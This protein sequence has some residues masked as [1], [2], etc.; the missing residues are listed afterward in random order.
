TYGMC[1]VEFGSPGVG[2]DGQP[3]LQPGWTTQISNSPP[4]AIACATPMSP[5]LGVHAHKTAAKPVG[6]GALELRHIHPPR[7]S[8]PPGRHRERGDRVEDRRGAALLPDVARAL[9]A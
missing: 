9:R 6:H 4:P 1:L 3:I 5:A 2:P 7:A 8:P